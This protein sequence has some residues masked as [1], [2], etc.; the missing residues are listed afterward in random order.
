MDPAE[1]PAPP[2]PEDGREVWL[3]R[4]RGDGLSRYADAAGQGLVAAGYRPGVAVDIDGVV[5][6]RFS[7]V[8]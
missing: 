7:K 5:L 6:V 2:P 3:V 4:Q 1:L 8:R